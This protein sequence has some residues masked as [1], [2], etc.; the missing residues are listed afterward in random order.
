MDPLTL[1]NKR[2]RKDGYL[3]RALPGLKN[4]FS[5]ESPLTSLMIKSCAVVGS[6]SKLLEKEY[7][8]EIDDHDY[9]IRFNRA[10]FLGYEK[11]VGKRTDARLIGRNWIFQENNEIM[12]HRYNSKKYMQVDIENDV[13]NDLYAFNILFMDDCDNNLRIFSK[14]RTTPSSG[15]MGVM[16]AMCLCN[17]VS[18]YGFWNPE[19][20][21]EKE[22]H[23]YPDKSNNGKKKGTVG[24]HNFS[25]ERNFYEN[26]INKYSRINLR[27]Q[28]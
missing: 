10:P 15:F 22:Y 13:N 4:H 20:D 25:E 9:V 8:K 12:I 18:L 6:S 16:M 26:I 17:N 3:K 21:S 28:D 7:G 24:P 2:Y 1:A 27:I 23:Y 5:K 11:H 19:T 14:K